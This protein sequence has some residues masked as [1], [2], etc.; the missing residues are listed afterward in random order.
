MYEKQILSESMLI[1]GRIEF[2]EFLKLALFELQ[3]FSKEHYD[4]EEF[5]DFFN[6]YAI[7]SREYIFKCLRNKARQRRI[8]TK[9]FDDLG[10]LLNEANG[11]DERIL[12]KTGQQAKSGN[13]VALTMT[14]NLLLSIYLDYLNK[15]FELELYSIPELPSVFNYLKFVY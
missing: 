9:Y 2:S 5:K 11:L 15:G 6:K 3:P 10:I 8:I 4:D 12:K 13:T 7:I 1:F 14:I